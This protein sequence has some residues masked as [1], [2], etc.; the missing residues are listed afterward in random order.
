MRQGGGTPPGGG[1]AAL[2]L[3]RMSRDRR[4]AL[5]S[6]LPPKLC[7]PKIKVLPHTGC[8]ALPPITR[9]GSARAAGA[10]GR[11]GMAWDVANAALFLASDEANFITGVA[12]PV[13]GGSLVRVG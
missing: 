5:E 7:R 1:G 9:N 12:L 2:P 10:H 8:A 6:T 11:I 13:D 3:T 4:R